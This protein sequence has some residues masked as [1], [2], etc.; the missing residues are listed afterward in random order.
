MMRAG[1]DQIAL[2]RVRPNPNIGPF[3]GMGVWVDLYDNW[4]WK[5]PAAAVADMAAHGARDKMTGANPSATTRIYISGDV[6]DCRVLAYSPVEADRTARS[7]SRPSRPA[8]F[9]RQCMEQG[10]MDSVL[11]C[12]ANGWLML[13]VGVV[14]YGTLVLAGAALIKYLRTE[15]KVGRQ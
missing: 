15:S 8:G 10:M 13:A 7:Q 12:G 3:Q 6:T 5:H 14:T 11:N 1:R 2:P 4:A 9:D